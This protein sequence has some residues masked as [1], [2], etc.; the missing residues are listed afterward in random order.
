MTPEP[1]RAKEIDVFVHR[2]AEPIDGFDGLTPL[3]EWL[4]H[5]TPHSAV[6]DAAYAAHPE[7]FVR[8]PPT[9][10]TLPKAAWINKTEHAPGI[11]A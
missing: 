9:P 4:R 2:L 5:A 7:R 10:P 8:H 6:L 3:P 11:L 1:F